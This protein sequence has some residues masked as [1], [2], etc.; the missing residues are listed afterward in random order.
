MTRPLPLTTARIAYRRYCNQ[1]NQRTFH[2]ALVPPSTP[3]VDGAPYL[4]NVNDDQR[5]EAY[6]L[7]IL[8]SIPFDWFVRLIVERNITF[9]VLETLPIPQPAT[10]PA[11]A[12]R[13]EEISGRLSATDDR[14]AAWAREVGVPV[15]AVTAAEERESLVSELDALASLMYGLSERQVELIFGSFRRGWNFQDRLD[16]VLL[17][18]RAW[19]ARLDQQG[20]SS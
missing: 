16:A 14:F 1:E 17:H 19:L 15:G 12:A 5:A 3:L 10:Y 11:L 9:D 18:Y 4:Y 8:S 13:V 6:L 7:G 20:V 2:T